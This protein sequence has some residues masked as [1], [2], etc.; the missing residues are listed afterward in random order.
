MVVVQATVA[1][2]QTWQGRERVKDAAKHLPLRVWLANESTGLLTME[3]GRDSLSRPWTRPAPFGQKVLR[4]NFQL[5]IIV[6]LLHSIFVL[7]NMFTH[8]VHQRSNMNRYQV[9]CRKPA[10]NWFFLKPHLLHFV[11]CFPSYV[12]FAGQ[13]SAAKKS[14]HRQ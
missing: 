7:K 13:S 8:S 3:T 2:W 6:G 4:V 14:L 11:K 5:Y 10:A 1:H 9:A 12:H